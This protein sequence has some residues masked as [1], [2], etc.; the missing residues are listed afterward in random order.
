MTRTEAF[1][2]RIYVDFSG[3]MG[4]PRK[5]GATKVVC[6]A[7]VLTS[8]QD[9]WHNEGMVVE[10]KRVIG[11]RQDDELKYRSLRRHSRKDEALTCLE[12]ARVGIVV[13]PVLKERVREDE[14]RDP[15]T[16]K[17]ALLL[18][19]FPLEVILKH[20]A[21]T[22]PKE[23][24]PSLVLQLVF[25][26]VGWAGFR[27]QIVHRLEEEHHIVWRLPPEESV[28]FENSKKSLMLQ[29]ADVVAGLAR[30]Y[31]ESL[32]SVPLP[33]CRICWVKGKRMRP[34]GC[35]MKPVGNAALM[36]ILRPLLLKTKGD[37]WERGFLVRPPAACYEF[38]F[39]DCVPWGKVER[40][41]RRVLSSQPKP[42]S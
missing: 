39:V 30:E 40:P 21:E 20:L 42:A 25:D 32:E 7:W 3:D 10:M 26:Q 15:T 13:V 8:E 22:I 33:P 36:R 28:R 19:H 41:L 24:L 2:H 34:R 4:D 1:S 16:N 14:L 12:Q 37:V 38:C 35:D 29:L 31:I 27:Q 6:I 18:H 11:C 17:L 9:R 23:E 5:K